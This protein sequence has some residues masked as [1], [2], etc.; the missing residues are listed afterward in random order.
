MT[1]AE[2]TQRLHAVMDEYKISHRRDL[3]FLSDI[4]WV[5]GIEIDF[6]A[7]PREKQIAED[8]PVCS[9]P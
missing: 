6:K 5:L 9:E 3:R 2:L 8:P 4:S 1:F 7:I